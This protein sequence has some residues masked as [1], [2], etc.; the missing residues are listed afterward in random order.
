ME[1]TITPTTGRLLVSKIN[2]K[3]TATASGILMPSETLQEENLIYGKV[4]KGNQA[5]KEGT[6]IFYSRYSAT[7]VVDD[8]GKEFFIISADDVMASEEYD[9][10]KV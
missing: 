3:D 8:K 4:V 9:A 7:K 5:F 2:R 10:P 1:T 6:T